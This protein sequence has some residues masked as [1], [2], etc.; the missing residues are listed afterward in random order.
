MEPAGIEPSSRQKQNAL[1]GAV[2]HRLAVKV[3]RNEVPFDAVWFR[4]EPLASAEFGH[5]LGT[6]RGAS[7]RLRIDSIV[8]FISGRSGAALFF[9]CDA[10]S[11]VSGKHFSRA[12]IRGSLE[13]GSKRVRRFLPEWWRAESIGGPSVNLNGSAAGR[14]S[15][16]LVARQKRARQVAGLAVAVDC[17]PGLDCFE[18][19]RSPV[20]PETLR[21]T[22][23]RVDEVRD[24]NADESWFCA[25]SPP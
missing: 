7:R 14:S 6:S 18:R 11:T 13:G 10:A 16:D 17:A 3:R 21:S 4:L 24:L 25:T 22:F 8:Q 20:P 12:T 19:D 23:E 1:R 9:R 15:C 5:I 2:L